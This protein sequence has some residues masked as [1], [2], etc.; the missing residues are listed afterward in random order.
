MAQ[1]TAARLKEIL[2]S[3]PPN[4]P[5]FLCTSIKG[6]LPLV[7]AGTTENGGGELWLESSLPGQGGDN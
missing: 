5:V 1:F 3:L 7:F 2:E 4:T 6:G